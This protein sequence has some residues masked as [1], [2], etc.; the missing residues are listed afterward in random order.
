M[1]VG[2]MNSISCLK[3]KERRWETVN[4]LKRDK[5]LK[6]V[7]LNFSEQTLLIMGEC[8]LLNQM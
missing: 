7:V 6:F 3:V 8:Q 1:K 2:S 5:Q 4:I